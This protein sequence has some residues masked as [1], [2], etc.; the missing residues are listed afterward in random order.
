MLA[1]Q[2]R[3]ARAPVRSIFRSEREVYS[4]TCDQ[5]RVYCGSVDG[6]L[7]VFC[8]LSGTLLYERYC[9][10]EDSLV[11]GVEGRGGVQ[12]DVGDTVVACIS[13]RAAQ[14]VVSVWEREEGAPLYLGKAHGETR[15]FG[16]RVVGEG[17]V[18]S[19]GSDGSLVVLGPLAWGWAAVSILSNYL[20]SYLQVQLC[21][22]QEG[23]L[24]SVLLQAGAE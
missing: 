21:C 5:D 13:D 24:P 12:V 2:W 15:V 18:V 20:T 8:R 9:H 11:P 23:R 19:G 10:T 1:R 14:G 3:E 7:Q 4:M 22:V 6:H 17:R 16:V